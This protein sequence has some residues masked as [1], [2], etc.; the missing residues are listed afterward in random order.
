MNEI[1]VND[2]ICPKCGS[3]KIVPIDE[4]TTAIG[5][6]FITYECDDCGEDWTEWPEQATNE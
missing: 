1:Y 5:R 2:K 4:N 6:D 3:K